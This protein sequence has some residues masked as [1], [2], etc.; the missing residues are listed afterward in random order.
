MSNDKGT[1][2]SRR[3]RLMLGAAILIA[4]TAPATAADVSFESWS[5][6]VQTT[7]KMIEATQAK[8]PDIRIHAKVFNYPDY[9]VDLP[10]RAASG[11]IADIIGLEPGALTQQYRKFLMPLQDC[12]ARAWG[13][14]WKDKLYP[15][16]VA[17][18]RLGNP[19]GDEN[20]YGLPILVQTINLWYTIP[21]LKDAGVDPPRTYDELARAAKILTD[22]G[23][24]P[25]LVGVG[26]G[27]VRRDIYMQLIHDI[28]PGLIYKAE[29]GQVKF[30]D[31][32]FV[33]AMRWWKKLF[34]DGIFQP[35][36]LGLSQYPNAADLIEGGRAGMFA[37]GAW[38]QQEATR[39]DP[40][41][42]AVGM[43]GFQPIKFPDVT[44]KGAPDDLLGGIDVMLGV[45]KTA[46]DPDAA[47]KVVTDWVSGAGAQTL[48]NTFNDLPAW[49]GMAPQT[50]VSDHQK[51]V[52]HIL[53]DEW[54]PQVKYAR[55]LRSPA[56]KQAF[57]D[58]L[59]AVASGEKTPEA[60]MAG[61]QAV[62]DKK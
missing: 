2:I 46:K 36:A 13:A 3:H 24:A 19:P 49:K 10:T 15:I 9:I 56:I 47:C 43:E 26:D 52:W 21:V 45:S 48:I 23:I 51:Q 14:D 17:Q 53:T 62:A 7:N 6:L 5:P 31:P 11:E 32:P 57:E 28:A 20:F 34:D 12:A 22:K 30:T 16:A 40:P 33:E 38:W 1:R 35:G 39:D 8:F 29:T 61:I 59:A 37:M 27:W 55:Q 4:G 44:G 50:Y 54:L 41:P 25:I 42:L 60:A 18:A 58:E